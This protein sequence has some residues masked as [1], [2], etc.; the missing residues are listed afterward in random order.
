MTSNR[1]LLV[2][3]P[4]IVTYLL[5]PQTA[6]AHRQYSPQQR[7]FMQRDPESEWAMSFADRVG[8]A[9]SQRDPSLYLYGPRLG[10]F[11]QENRISFAFLPPPHYHLYSTG[12]NPLAYVDPSGLCDYPGSEADYDFLHLRDNQ[13]TTCWCLIAAKSGIMPVNDSRCQSLSECVTQIQ[14]AINANCQCWNTCITDCSN[15]PSWV[16]YL[17][18]HSCWSG[19]HHDVPDCP[20]H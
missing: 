6:E 17:C 4:G 5:I 18:R 8:S 9:N 7:R 15:V 1:F 20:H 14:D 19:C 10:S 3:M 13:A 2:V 16:G 12:N 11:D